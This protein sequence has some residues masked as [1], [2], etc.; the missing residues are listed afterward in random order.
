MN[1]G[2]LGFIVGFAVATLISAA[3][4]V[5]AQQTTS[6][7]LFGSASG[8]PKV[9]AVDASGNLSLKVN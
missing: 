7:L 8:V 3:L 6:I 4:E 2:T 1:R 5:G 9:L